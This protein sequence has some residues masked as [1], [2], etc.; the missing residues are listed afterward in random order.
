MIPRRTLISHAEVRGV[1]LFSAQPCTAFFDPA[2]AGT[3]IV[4]VR[5]DLPDSPRIPALVE[6]LAAPPPGIPA[7]NTTLLSAGAEVL[8]VEHVLSALTGL[9]VSDCTITLD[10]PEIP[11]GDGS[12]AP[13][14][15]AL[16]KAGLRYLGGDSPPLA[17]STA[18]TVTGRDGAHITAEPRIRPGCSYTYDL[19]YGSVILRQ[20]AAFD[21][22]TSTRSGAFRDYARDIAP[23][24]T[25]CTKVEADA[26]QKAGLFKHLTASDMLVIGERGP[27]DNTYRFDN[28]PARHKLLDLIGDLALTSRALQA[29]IRAHKSGHALNHEMAKALLAAAQK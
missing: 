10:G 17:I 21:T 6:H 18:I 7:R 13:F 19:D 12:A 8:T 27:I 28:E 14:A 1:G 4:F 22:D 29:D 23:A 20:S 24:R 25:F 5:K 11:I 16:W 9:G 2:P 3:G 26:M 15:S